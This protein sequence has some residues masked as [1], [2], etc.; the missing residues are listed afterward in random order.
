MATVRGQGG[1]PVIVLRVVVRAPDLD[2]FIERYARQID[3]DRIFIFTKSPQPPGTRVRFSLQ[4]ASGETLIQGR[5]TVIRVQPDTGDPRR[6]PGMELVFVPADDRSQT[7]VDFMLATRAGAV[8]T[9]A[10]PLPPPSDFEENCP[11][12]VDEGPHVEALARAVLA[13]P[14]PLPPAAKAPAPVKA[15]APAPA[16]TA[17]EAAKAP[18]SASAPASTSA[19]APAPDPAA[20]IAEALSAAGIDPAPE[21]VRPTAAPAF[22]ERWREPEPPGAAAARDP[23]VPANPFSEI[24][25]G[26][27]E[28][29]VEWSLEQSIGPRREPTASF[30]D[31]AMALPGAATD[32]ETP[33]V[34]RLRQAGLVAAGVALGLGLGLVIA[35]SP[36]PAPALESP[37]RAAPAAVTAAVPPSA[38]TAPAPAPE[39]APPAP[40]PAPPAPEPAAPAPEVSGQPTRFVSRPPGAQVLIDGAPAGVTPLTVPLAA[41]P[42]AVVLRKERYQVVRTSVSAPGT[43]AVT[44][45][46]PLARV[47]VTSTP[48]GAVVVI[49]GVPRGKT[50]LEV[51]LPAYEQYDVQVAAAGGKSWRKPVYVRTPVTAVQAPL[52]VPPTRSV[53]R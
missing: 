25:D 3:G 45:R 52:A 53:K 36:A 33:R 2:T 12:N 50:P 32:G 22:A 24:S 5:G 40:E 11:T 18:A 15:A 31:V 1:A 39:P 49:A 20:K 48:P 28:Y 29:F 13:V 9:V 7:L 34:R 17:P 30:S 44:L 43:V 10:P 42:H 26:A 8:E 21:P 27:I 16:E 23:S 37:A 41:G 47:T 35:K 46:R 19:P 38:S 14:P 51:K 4:L 6:P